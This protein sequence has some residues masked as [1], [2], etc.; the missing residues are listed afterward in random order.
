MLHMQVSA[1]EQGDILPFQ[2]LYELLAVLDGTIIRIHLAL[3]QQ[4]VVGNRK[5]NHAVAGSLL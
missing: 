1:E 4:V 5:K 2:H 3:L